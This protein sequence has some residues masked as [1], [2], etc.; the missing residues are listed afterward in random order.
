VRNSVRLEG[1]VGGRLF[2]S[3]ASLRS[4]LLVPPRLSRDGGECPRVF[5]LA[6][7]LRCLAPFR[8]CLVFWKWPDLMEIIGEVRPL[9]L[10]ASKASRFAHRHYYVPLPSG[11]RLS[12]FVRFM[13]GYFG[14]LLRRWS[15][16][17]A[18][19]VFFF[20][21]WNSAIVWA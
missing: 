20:S 4:P 12:F 21:I 7:D 16:V 1:R 11:K 5:F 19:R 6:G 9:R 15:V 18:L 13:N 10:I 3:F 17:L 14:V 8:P 2:F